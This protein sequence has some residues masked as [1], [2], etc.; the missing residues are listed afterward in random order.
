MMGEANNAQQVTR[1]DNLLKMQ[2]RRENQ[3]EVLKGRYTLKINS[4]CPMNKKI[5]KFA[6]E[7]MSFYLHKKNDFF[8]RLTGKDKIIKFKKEEKGLRTII[9]NILT[10]DAFINDEVK[11]PVSSSPISFKERMN[12]LK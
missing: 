9:K 5:E 7:P 2:D 11:L 12:R 1:V 6:C 10:S 3:I 4:K 8:T